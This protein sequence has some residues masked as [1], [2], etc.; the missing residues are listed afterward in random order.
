MLRL[1]GQQTKPDM[2][3]NPLTL[4]SK[5]FRPQVV[6]GVSTVKK[7]T[8]YKSGASKIEGFTAV[9]VVD[10]FAACKMPSPRYLHD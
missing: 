10:R 2:L 5:P 4:L 6:V 1:T 9:A 3:T 7:H 8:P